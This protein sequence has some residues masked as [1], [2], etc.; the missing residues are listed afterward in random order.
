MN[1]PGKHWLA[2]P[3]LLLLAACSV[4]SPERRLQL[5]TDQRE[6][7][8]ERAGAFFTNTI[9]IKPREPTAA[10][11]PEWKLAPLF[12][13]EVAGSN[14]PTR[15][16]IDLSDVSFLRGEV[17]ISG[18]VHEQ[19]VFAWKHPAHNAR[20]G[21]RITMNASGNPVIWEVLADPPGNDLVFVSQNFEA[22]AIREF[23]PPL[24][25]RRF[26]VERDVEQ[27]PST[28]VARILEDASEIM[29]PVAYLDASGDVSTLACR[30]M[31]S[32]AK[33]ATGTSYYELIPAATVT[34]Q[35]AFPIAGEEH[36]R[37]RLRV[38][39]DF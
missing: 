3:N 34:N 10:A 32:Q 38:P 39:Q 17:L 30:C 15:E 31:P 29:G 21:L 23:G 27:A 5:T 24:P 20:Q 37:R 26:S 7:I 16:Q 12:V 2:L 11:S 22:A 33:T 19:V 8:Y 35:S 6:K 25:G 18:R 4:A 36:L 14:A 28:V 9:L 1:F 13:R